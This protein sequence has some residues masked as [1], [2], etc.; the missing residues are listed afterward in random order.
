[1]RRV[2]N[3]QVPKIETG[4]WISSVDD[5]AFVNT[6]HVPVHCYL[7]GNYSRGTKNDGNVQI[8]TG[9]AEK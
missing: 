5:D 1:M 8:E 3:L 7:P 4:V 2:G 9:G 6:D